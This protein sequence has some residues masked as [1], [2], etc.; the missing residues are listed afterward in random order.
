MASQKELR[1]PWFL[2]SDK[3]PQLPGLAPALLPRVR[4]RT[5]LLEDPQC[6]GMVLGDA[7]GSLGDR[8]C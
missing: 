7:L 6:A 2:A 1:K 8:S 4:S 3:L 5:H